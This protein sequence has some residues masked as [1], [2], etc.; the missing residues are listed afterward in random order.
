MTGSV[1]PSFSFIIPYRDHSGHHKNLLT[2]LQWIKNLHAEVIVVEEGSQERLQLPFPWVKKVFIYSPHSFNK[3]WALNVGAEKATTDRLVFTDADLLLKQSDI[4]KGISLLDDYDAVS[5]YSEVV[6]LTEEESEQAM[7]KFP[8]CMQREGR[9]FINFAGGV[10][11]MKREAFESIGGWCEEFFGWGGEDNFM[12]WKIYKWLDWNELSATA[13]HL[14]HKRN[15]PDNNLYDFNIQVFNRVDTYGDE[16]LINWVC[17]SGIWKGDKNR[18]DKVPLKETKTLVIEVDNSNHGSSMSA[19][20]LTNSREE[21]HEV[22]RNDLSDRVK[23]G[24]VKN[25]V[26]V[27]KGCFFHNS[28]WYNAIEKTSSDGGP[29]LLFDHDIICVHNDFHRQVISKEPVPLGKNIAS[30]YIWGAVALNYAICDRELLALFEDGD[31]LKIK[32]Y[33]KN[34]DSVSGAC[35]IKDEAFFCETKTENLPLE[36]KN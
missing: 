21:Q 9:P 30:D 3:S 19:L 11:M 23:E 7:E 17:Y 6:D 25:I 4:L 31:P 10:L 27:Q 24:Q 36:Y 28:Q 5:P 29:V 12:T 16:D 20:N 13:Y 35:L 15:E 34:G 1:A 18:F 32:E 8:D 22:N 26:F 33:F 14:W 2:V